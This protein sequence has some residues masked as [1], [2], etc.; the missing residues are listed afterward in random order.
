MAK[1][2]FMHL[3]DELSGFLKNEK[4]DE[5]IDHLKNLVGQRPDESVLAH[6]SIDQW[7]LPK[8]IKKDSK[9]IAL[10]SD[11]ACRGNPGPGAWAIMAQD[12][13]G[14]LLFESSGV[15]FQTTNNKMELNGAIESLKQIK[16]YFQENGMKLSSHHFYLY[17]DS[18]YVVDGI[19]KWVPNWKKK[20][21]KKA[22]NKTVENVE[23]WKDLDQIFSEIKNV[24]F[25]WVKGHAGH[26]QNE[27][28]DRLANEALDNAGL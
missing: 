6:N 10:F 3:L 15:E 8:E 9:A 16:E 1:K 23:Y 18:K 17:S 26:P 21:W 2:R 14:K 7:P 5:F 20:N 19:V 28:C 12:G 24:S 4:A 27:H 13:T 22:D 25:N 11:G